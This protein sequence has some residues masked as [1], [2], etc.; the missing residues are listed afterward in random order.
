MKP[1]GTMKS[2]NIELLIVLLFSFIL[3]SCSP[4]YVSLPPYP[5]PPGNVSKPSRLPSSE[6]RT[7]PPALVHPQDLDSQEPAYKIPQSQTPQHIASL[8][9]VEQAREFALSGR[10]DQAI[11][12]LERAIELDSYNG[13]AFYE[14]ARCWEIKGNHEKALTFIDRSIRIFQG[15]PEKLKKSYMLKS[16][17]L[18]AAGENEEAEHFRS[19]ANSL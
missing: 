17:I 15:N 4:S 19:L 9:L 3:S 8:K 16:A 18:K 13:E 5:P 1:I 2:L 11:E 12:Y 10:V 7:N 6:Q 14:M